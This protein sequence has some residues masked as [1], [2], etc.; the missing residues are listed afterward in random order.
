MKLLKNLKLLFK[1][2]DYKEIAAILGVKPRTVYFWKYHG[3]P[4]NVQGLL[5]LIEKQQKELI[6]LKEKDN[7]AM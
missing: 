1:C 7:Y 2:D 6:E 4:S 3:L 5:K